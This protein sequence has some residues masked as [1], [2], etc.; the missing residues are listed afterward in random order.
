MFEAERIIGPDFE[1]NRLIEFLRP[2]FRKFEL[3]T[4]MSPARAATVLQKIVEP[5]KIFRWP[6]SRRHRY[7]EGT[8]EGDHFKINRIINHRDLFLPIIEGSFRE[9]D[10]GT[11]VTLNMRMAWPVVVF[12]SGFILALLWSFVRQSAFQGTQTGL[13]GM[14]LFMYFLATV[15]FATEVRIAM[16]RLLRLLR[17]GEIR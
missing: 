5:A 15:Y 9:E 3:L 12:C 14:M 2:P 1:P 10:S 11:L 8:V 7:F 16:K 4:P 6:S 13:I 17:S